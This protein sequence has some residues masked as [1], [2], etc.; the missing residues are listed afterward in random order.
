[1][2][3]RS[4]APDDDRVLEGFGY[5]P[6]L[7]RVLRT[8]SSFAIVFSFISISTG[9]F[10]TFGAI[11]NGAGPRGIWSWPLVCGGQLFVVFLL[12]ALAGRIPVSGLSYQWMSRLTSPSVGWF[13][14]WAFLG[15]G[16]ITAAVVNNIIVGSLA[17]VLSVSIST[18]GATLIVI[19]LTLIQ[20]AMLI[21]STRITTKVNNVAVWTEMASVTIFGIVLIVIGLVSAK[22]GG[23][24]HSLTSSAPIP[25]AGYWAFFG[26]FF[27]VVLAGAFTYTG[28][29]AA[30]ALADETERPYMAVPKGIVQG[31]VLSA[32]MGMLFLLGITLAA[33]GDWKAVGAAASPVGFVAQNRL[34]TAVGDIVIICVMV[35]IFA[36]ALIQTTVASRLLWAM[37]RDGRFPASGLFHRINP[38]TETPINAI[39]FAMVVEVIFAIFSTHLADLIAASAL[40]P[41]GV[42]F[43]ISVAYLA[44]RNR[45]PVQPGGFSLGRFDLPV[46][47]AS[48]I[49]GILLMVWLVEPAANHKSVY[50]ALG[51]FASGALWWLCLRAFAPGRLSGAPSPDATAPQSHES[52]TMPSSQELV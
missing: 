16:L 48:V 19:G 44:R 52:A 1:M 36:N 31:S 34:G 5:K 39:I 24:T 43:A 49:W 29:D 32:V 22:H 17:Q 9:I 28:F 26:P 2:E 18:T 10:A 6:E 23:G 3:S 12:A 15:Y 25:A 4:T 50:I 30:A 27:G 20:G 45:F 8:F 35:A 40:I 51:I 21:S 11:V 13:L 38:H 41:V 7:R 46:A 33:P 37:S 14:G 47:V 42:Y